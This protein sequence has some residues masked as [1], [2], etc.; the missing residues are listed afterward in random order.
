MI[1]D[2]TLLIDKTLESLDD[3]CPNNNNAFS[4]RRD[5]NLLTCMFSM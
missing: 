5:N 3:C 4:T 1:T 2:D